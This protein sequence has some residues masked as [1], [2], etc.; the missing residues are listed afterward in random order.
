MKS[1]DIISARAVELAEDSPL[2]VAAAALPVGE[3]PNVSA[4]QI[5]EQLML[6]VPLRRAA[7][8]DDGSTIFRLWATISKTGLAPLSDPE[9]SVLLA[10]N[11]DTKRVMLSFS[12][13]RE[14]PVLVMM[15]G[16]FVALCHKGRFSI[17]GIGGSPQISGISFAP[18]PPGEQGAL[19]TKLIE[20][21]AYKAN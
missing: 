6:G 3:F 4:E 10:Y 21:F 16:N 5:N 17:A 11:A 20:E 15:A 2:V 18:S 13:A 9:D 19:A 12:A 8:R 14:K 7:L 1:D